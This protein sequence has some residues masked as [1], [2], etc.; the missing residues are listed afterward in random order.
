MP[1]IHPGGCTVMTAI[2]LVVWVCL[3]SLF[4]IVIGKLIE[5]GTHDLETVKVQLR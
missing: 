1:G 3:S 2:I 4:A 5:V